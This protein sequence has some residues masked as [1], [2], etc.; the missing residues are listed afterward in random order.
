[1]SW[2]SHGILRGCL[3]LIKILLNPIKIHDISIEFWRLFRPKRCQKMTSSVM[4]FQWHPIGF[5]YQGNSILS[6]NFP[7]LQEKRRKNQQEWRTWSWWRQRRNS[8][9]IPIINSK[10]SK[11]TLIE[12]MGWFHW[13]W[14]VSGFFALFSIYS[15]LWHSARHLPLWGAYWCCIYF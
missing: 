2:H 10:S 15:W 14:S 3:F 1:M 11:I 4:T 6:Y 7:G 12:S 5:F 9:T 13:S 8:C